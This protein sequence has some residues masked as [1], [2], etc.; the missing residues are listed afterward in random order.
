[1]AGK[2]KRESGQ[3]LV[4]LALSF[5]FILL[6]L[7]GAVDI[8]RAFFSYIAIRDAAQEGAVYGALYPDATDVT[9]RVRNSAT[10]AG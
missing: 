5:T 3:S 1:M 7:S 2:N 4:E 9:T 8:G 10:I 6:I